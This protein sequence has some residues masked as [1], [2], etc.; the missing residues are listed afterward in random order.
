LAA[1]RWGKSVVVAIVVAAALALYFSRVSARDLALQRQ[2]GPAII[3]LVQQQY[4]PS[5]K[6]MAMHPLGNFEWVATVNPVDCTFQRPRMRDCWEVY[7]GARVAGPD[8]LGR[9][10][11]KV[12]ANFIVDG[13]A[14]RILPVPPG[15]R[16]LFDRK[17][18]QPGPENDRISGRNRPH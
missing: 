6:L 18:P 15:V 14:M 9:S 8:P 12:E 1:N 4:A 2:K 10:P 3:A 11:G 13:D 7:F 17:T 16:A 5:Q